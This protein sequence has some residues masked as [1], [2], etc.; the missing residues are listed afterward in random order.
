[1]KERKN[2]SF[3]EMLIESS[4]LEVPRNTYQRGLNPE[5]VKRIM[6]DFDERIANEPKISLRN[7][8][9][10]VFDGQH[11]VAARVGRNAGVDLPVRCKVY[12]GLSDKEEA[13]LF[14]NQAGH[15][16]VPGIGLKLRALVYSGDPEACLF[17]K[18]TEELG[19]KV[20]YGQ[21]KGKYRLACIAAALVEFRKLGPDKYQEALRLILEGWDGDPDSLRAETVTGVCRFVDLYFGEY[22]RKRV[23]KRFR[24]VDPIKIYRDGRAIGENMPGYKK[25]LMQVV[26]IYNGSSRKAALPVK[27]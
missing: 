2:N 18:K 17:L 8:H 15:S 19:L 1:M 3:Q 16:A 21:H 26:T 20:D 4:L 9:Y 23:V 22:D 12:S 5:R 27:F 11:I 7:G 14:A 6:N 25:Y 10:Y 24:S 13:K